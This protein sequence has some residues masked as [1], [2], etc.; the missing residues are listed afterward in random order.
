M[1]PGHSISSATDIRSLS[2]ADVVWLV[3][4][5]EQVHIERPSRDEE[6]RF[7]WFKLDW[8][9]LDI[10]NGEQDPDSSL[11]Q[12]GYHGACKKIADQFAYSDQNNTLV[13]SSPAN[14]KRFEALVRYCYWATKSNSTDY[15]CG[16]LA[17][18]LLSIGNFPAGKA[19]LKYAPGCHTTRN[20]G[21]P[22][23]G[24]F[25]TA[26][27]AERIK[28]FA[29]ALDTIDGDGNVTKRTDQFGAG[30][31]TITPADLL[32]I[33]EPACN[34]DLDSEA[35]SY[36]KGH[37]G[38]VQFND[39]QLKDIS[40]R[41][42]EYLNWLQG[43]VQERDQQREQRAD[44]QQQEFDDRMK[45]LRNMANQTSSLVLDAGNQQAAA[46]RAVGDTNAV[47][48]QAAAQQAAAQQ[49][50]AAQR[51]AQQ[52][53]SNRSSNA[54]SSAAQTTGA[55]LP[56][57]HEFAPL[58]VR[59]GTVSGYQGNAHVVST[60]PGID[61]PSTCSFQFGENV[62]VMLFATADQSS[63]VKYLTCQ[64]SSG[65][66]ML[67][68]GNEM[69]CSI[70]QWAYE[71]GPVTVYVD[72]YPPPGTNSSTSNGLGANGSRS[73]GNGNASGTGGSGSS[74]GNS[75]SYLAPIAQSCVREFWDPKFYNWLSFANDC[76][77]AINLTWIAKNLN[78]H[79]GGANAI[80]AAGQSTN[81]G[82]SQTEV[83]AKGGFTLFI[84]PAGSVAVDGNTHQMVSSPNATYSCKK[85]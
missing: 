40:A 82:W 59:F 45:T 66:G 81:T 47:E 58:T 73:G 14:P 54:Q 75:G 31:S 10:C 22:T 62:A 32:F 46:I 8:A 79:F 80:I 84:C 20:D 15:A 1:G 85:Q 6:R 48:Q 27:Q 71:G 50:A 39:K 55:T 19:V 41:N 61:C 7:K 37:G 63:A 29:N 30:L 12:T 70:P 42:G 35:C 33:A 52:T 13:L 4:H 64:M 72:I 26:Y 36:T 76:G 65:T 67:Q 83:A 2:G 57:G 9:A 21:E 28:V 5:P 78:D 11:I 44:E 49:R 69:S 25:R 51:S 68:A 74:G 3:T 38:H 56:T 23:S 34:L 18:A 43:W 60:P 53:A 24:C 17:E 77:Q 16:M